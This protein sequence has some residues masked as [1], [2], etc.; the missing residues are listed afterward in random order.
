MSDGAKTA[1][2]SVI[3]C[4]RDRDAPAA[5]AWLRRAFGFAEHRVVPGE[6][7]T[8]AHAQLS[9]ANGMIMLG[10]SDDGE[11]GRWVRTRARRS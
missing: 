3:P 6:N 1:V 4:L 5:I 9:F 8:I 10:S 11:F 2:A 7:G